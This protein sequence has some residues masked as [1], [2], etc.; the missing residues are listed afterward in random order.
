MTRD[1]ERI[2][3]KFAGA[4]AA[5]ANGSPADVRDA[6]AFI[7]SPEFSADNDDAMR[8]AINAFAYFLEHNAR[9]RERVYRETYGMK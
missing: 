8:S 6:A 1:A 4:I 3:N 5:V 9:K 7:R 2:A